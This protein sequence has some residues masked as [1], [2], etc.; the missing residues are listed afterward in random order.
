MSAVAVGRRERRG[1]D[2]DRRR[3]AGAVR[4]EQREELAGPDVEADAVDGVALPL[5]VTLRQALD[6]DHVVQPTRQAWT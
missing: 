6:V 5:L 1:Q 3:L 2:R 4:A